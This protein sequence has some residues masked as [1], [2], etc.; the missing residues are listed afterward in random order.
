MIWAASPTPDPDPGEFEGAAAFLPG[1]PLS[2][3]GSRLGEAFSLC[4]WCHELSFQWPGPPS[5]GLSPV[6]LLGHLGHLGGVCL[7]VPGCSSLS[8][9]Q[10]YFQSDRPTRVGRAHPPPPVP[11]A[12]GKSSWGWRRCYDKGMP[13]GIHLQQAFLKLGQGLRSVYTA[14]RMSAAVCLPSA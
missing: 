14:Q 8:C 3:S 10:C 4:T 5:A 6:L 12:P 2:S 7:I 1:S 9:K 13:S 11:V